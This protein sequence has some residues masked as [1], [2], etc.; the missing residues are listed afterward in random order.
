MLQES[1]WITP[2]PI[3][4]DTL[5]F[6]D[7]IGLSQQVFIFEVPQ[8]RGGDPKERTKVRNEYL[9]FIASLPPLPQE[10]LPEAL[11]DMRE[12]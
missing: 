2:L 1:V 11:K 10:L 6:I 4:E 5:E 3:G 12:V 8:L 9:Q 7:S